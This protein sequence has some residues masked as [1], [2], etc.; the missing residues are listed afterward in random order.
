MKDLT[1]L[2]EYELATL[3]LTTAISGS[4]SSSYGEGK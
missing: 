2:T 4:V 1:E 3:D